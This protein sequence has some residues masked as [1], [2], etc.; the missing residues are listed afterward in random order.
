MKHISFGARESVKDR[1]DKVDKDLS[2]AVP[3][4]IA[5][6]VDMSQISVFYQG[7]LGVCTG[8]ALVVAIIE[9]LY[10]KKT[11]VYTKLSV[12][13]LYIVT[14]LKV[15]QNFIEGSS[16]RSA[17]KAALKYGVC[18]E[19]T[20]R[21]NIEMSHADFISQHIPDN[22]WTEALNFTIGG[23]V[24]VPVDASLI[25][26]AMYK[27]G[28]LYARFEVGNKWYTPS[29]EEKDLSPLTKS[30][31]I[32]SGHAVA[33][34]A[35]DLS[36]E[37]QPMWLRN[38]WSDAWFRKGDGTFNFRDYKPTEVWAVSLDS[39][40]TL[41]SAPSLLDNVSKQFLNLLRMLHIIY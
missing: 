10:W 11:G 32:E 14:K 41:P 7:K 20:F 12:A 13:F 24:S 27:Y 30:A 15:D 3:Y 35:Y 39:L 9:Y 40:A 4:P 1:R 26:A 6:E 21:T 31:V 2:L 19:D 34:T 8:A 22:A 29:W 33:L 37:E 38:S 18:K 28:P 23:Y 25:A 17:L 16:L 36:K 5:Y